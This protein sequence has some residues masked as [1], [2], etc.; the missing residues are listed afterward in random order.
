[1][2]ASAATFVV[3]ADRVLVQQAPAI[4]VAT[5]LSS[6]VEVTSDDEVVTITTFSLGEVL[7]GN[8]GEDPF[9]VREP[10]G[11]LD[12]RI[13]AVHGAPRFNE[14]DEYL[15]F[16]MRT[17]DS[18]FSVRDLALGKFSFATDAMGRRL[19]IR[20][21]T[22]IN[23]WSADGQRHSERRREAAGFMRFI[24]ATV[25]GGPAR[26]D[27]FVPRDPLIAV[28]NSATSDGFLPLVTGAFS[29]TSYT[30]DFG[31]GRGARWNVFPSAVA[32][33]SVG[34]EPGAPGGGVTAIN[35]AFAAWNNEPNSNVNLVYSGTGSSSAGI[36][37]TD[38]VNSISFERNLTAHGVPRFSCSGNSYSGT[39]G[40]GGITNASGTHTGPNSEVFFT[41][42]EGDVEMNQ[43]IANCTLLFNNG[44]F[45]SAVTHEVGHSLGFRHSD[46]SRD[47]SGPCGGNLECSTTAIMKSFISS[48]LNATLQPWDRNAVAA[49]YPGASGG[50]TITLPPITFTDDPLVAR[51]TVIKAV[52]LA[53]LRNRVNVLRSAAGLPSASWT[54]PA[55]PGVVVKAVHVLELR[56]AVDP[57]LSA[58]GR[59]AG[60]WTDALGPG[61][62]IKAVHFQEI[63]NR[64]K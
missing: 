8:V 31:G 1:V 54:D 63:R 5:A 13:A 50:G 19:A 7:K 3:P 57:A 64:V 43:G 21:E 49:V 44:D 42:R 30:M 24:R 52:H 27:Y 6:R 41:A 28:G 55:S 17:G 34:T 59:V 51:Q 53:E 4:V 36:G 40:L 58:L 48:G 14:G 11:V 2:P 33:N 37:A 47:S 12:D 38:G 15:L 29:A 45:N 60:G 32:F 18:W 10:G 9:E 56:N 46:Q 35:A 20:D 23:G 61:V 39:L 22:E 25:A 26:E 16:L 62:V